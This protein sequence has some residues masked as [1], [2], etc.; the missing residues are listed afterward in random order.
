MRFASLGSGSSGNALVVQAGETCLMV[1]CG[2]GLRETQV[3]L[4]RLGLEPS[5]ISAVVVTHEHSDHIGGVMRLGAAWKL[6][7]H[8]TYGTLQAIGGVPKVLLGTEQIRVIDSHRAFSIGGLQVQPFPVPH[9]AREPVQYVFSDGHHR[10]GLL[11]DT[12]CS[13]PHIQTML[14][15]CDALVLECNHDEQML[16]AGRYPPSLKARIAGRYGHLSNEAAASLL[17]SLDRSRLRQLVAAHLSRDNN[18]PA[19]A[20]NALAS[21]IGCEQNWVEVADQEQGFDWREL[22]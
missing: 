22:G 19:L 3:R 1:D 18:S 21:A 15:G 5:V 14:S 10:L 17:K 16:A 12:G 11:T 6:P 8:L 4:G 7:V 20:R 9:D 2:F 13:T